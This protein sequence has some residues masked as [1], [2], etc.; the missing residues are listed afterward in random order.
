MIRYAK[1]RGVQWVYFT[2][3]ATLLNRDKAEELITSGLDSI[4]FSFDGATAE[5]YE[6]IRVKAKYDE[7]VNNIVYFSNLKKKLGMDKPKIIINTILMR[8]TQDEIFQVFE[9]WEPYVEK[10]NILP[11]GKYGNVNDL[12][13]IQRQTTPPNRIPCNQIFD[14]LLIFWDG[15]VTV[16]CADIDG[17]LSVGNIREHRIEELWR[18]EKFSELRRKHLQQEVDTIPICKVCDATDAEYNQEMKTLR[19]DIYKQARAI[20]YSRFF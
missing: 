7:V 6:K 5:T 3:N 13:P 2:S 20:G 10:I 14:R 19:Q 9:K 15:T 11:V 17:A 1:D 18:N 12:A 16:C 4:T 8:D